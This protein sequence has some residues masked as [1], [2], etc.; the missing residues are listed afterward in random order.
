MPDQIKHVVAL[1]LEN[2]S[3]DHMLGDLRHENPALDG[4]DPDKPNRIEFEGEPY[5]QA[6]GAAR[7]LVPDPKHEYEHVLRQIS[8]NDN[9]GFVRD[10]AE[11]SPHAKEK[12]REVMLYHAAGSLPALHTLAR[13]FLVCDHW[14]ASVPGPT[15]PN[16]LFALS[17]TS[18]G[19]VTMPEGL[20]SWNL[21]WYD[22]PTIFDRLTERGKTWKVYFTDFALSFLLTHQWEP[23]NVANY[24]HMPQFYRDA[25]QNP[26]DF[27]AF[28]LI[29]PAYMPP[30][31]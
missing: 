7:V 6:S 31:A 13:N 17:G 2:R 28:A 30:G 3:F 19:R 15:W 5:P 12:W 18:L 21:H 16:R 26:D 14:Y 20:F 29:E 27:P 1:I 9:S 24:H 23:Q 11:A 25:A 8:K 4:I 22:Q 10:F